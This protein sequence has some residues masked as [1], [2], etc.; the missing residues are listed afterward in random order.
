MQLSAH[1]IHKLTNQPILFNLSVG[2]LHSW[3]LLRISNKMCCARETGFFIVF[4]AAR[5]K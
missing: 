1:K 2:P 4:I 3:N 5:D